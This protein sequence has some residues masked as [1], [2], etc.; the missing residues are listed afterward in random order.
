[1]KFL[2]IL[3]VGVAILKLLKAKDNFLIWRRDLELEKISSGVQC[4][5]P[6]INGNSFSNFED[7]P[8][9]EIPFILTNLTD[10]WKAHINWQKQNLLKRFGDRQIR[11]GSESSIVY[12]GG[13]AEFS[14][15]L[16]TL[17]EGFELTDDLSQDQFAFDTT[18]LSAIPEIKD[19]FSPPTIFEWDQKHREANREVWH[20]L[21][22]GA[23]RAGK[24]IFIL[25]YLTF[26]FI[27]F[28]NRTAF[29]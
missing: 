23:S 27:R 24:E 7:I 18:I 5:F 15:T 6:V 28:L 12:S 11:S 8:Y 1:M 4:D 20:M 10:D 2:S 26:S 14:T 19:D 3:T 16:E 21:S 9:K 17:I 25:I 29:S 22:L 13:N